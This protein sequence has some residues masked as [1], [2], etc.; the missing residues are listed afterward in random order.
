MKNLKT[1]VLAAALGLASMTVASAKTYNLV[2]S[3]PAT[4]AGLQ[5]PAGSYKVNV[6]SRFA[7][8]TNLE[9]NKS[10]MVLY[11]LDSSNTVYDHTAVDLKSEAG[12]QRIESIELE[13]S[14]NKLE[15]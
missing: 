10:V 2:L 12:A 11:R 6:S 15:F 1:I 13:N 8:F 7:M 4:A 14:G 5:L 9:S 3:T